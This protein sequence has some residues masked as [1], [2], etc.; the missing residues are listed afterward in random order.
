MFIVD[1]LKY[2][3]VKYKKILECLKESLIKF[4]VETVDEDL[5]EADFWY[6]GI[7]RA[8][9]SKSTDIICFEIRNNSEVLGFII[10][11]I[12]KDEFFFIRH[13]FILEIDDREELAYIFLKET[14]ER[15]KSK[16]KINK[17]QNAAFTFP[18]DYLANPLKRIGFSILKRHNMTL[19]LK[20]FDK[21]F[22]L[23]PEFSFIPF[24]EEFIPIIAEVGIQTYR[25]H[26][27]A[28]FWDE[29][30]SDSLYLESL[31]ESLTTYLLTDC[32]ILVMDKNENIVGFCL[33]EK[34]FKEDDFII[35]N[36][37][38]NKEYQG[39]GVGK[40]LLSKVL[41]ITRDKD[42]KKAILTVTDGIPAQ[43]LYKNFGFK[44]Y[45]SFNIITNE[46]S[47]L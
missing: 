28:S 40:A 6:E 42:Y 24:K 8:I 27:D 31:K 44:K 38:V 26:P 35:Q 46:R 4:F 32:S 47:T 25:N 23:P 5:K 9:K 7:E 41:K 30:N 3:R 17:F 13:F 14:C 1:E 22:K 18:D 15:L 36:I 11:R 21:M 34:G 20:N 12:L 29:I 45:T 37:G 39:L 16:Y 10:T 2:S 19:N 43:K 33:I